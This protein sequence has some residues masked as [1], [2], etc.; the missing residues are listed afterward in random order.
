MTRNELIK[1][2]NDNFEAD[3]EINF[4]YY[5][6]GNDVRTAKCTAKIHCTEEIIGYNVWLDFVKDENGNLVKQWIRL[7]NEQVRD[8]NTNFR[9]NGDY[10]TRDEIKNRM[11][12]ITDRVINDKKKCLFIDE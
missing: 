11:Q 4:V 2:L 8:I 12:W 1:Y 10:L 9:W 6:D 5:D 3:E 7:T